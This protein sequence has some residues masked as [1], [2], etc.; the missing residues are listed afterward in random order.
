[1]SAI[2]VDRD[3]RVLTITMN[4]PP[5]NFLTT[6]MMAE[7]H[8]LLASVEHDPAIGAVV[9]TSALDGV[10]ITHFDVSEILSGSDDFSVSISPTVAGALLRTQG[11]I[12]HL[13]GVRSALAQSPAAG[14]SALLQFHQTCALVQRLDKVVIAAI[15][16]R[17]MGGGSELALC[18]DIRI[19]ADGDFALGQPEICLGI[20]PGGGGTQRLSRAV[21]HARALELM[22]EGRAVYPAEAKAIGYVHHVVAP[23]EFT[24]FVTETAHRLAR[25]PAAAVAAIKRTVNGDAALAR[26]LAT[27]R[28]EFSASVSTKQARAALRAYLDHLDELEARGEPLDAD[29]L[30]PWLEGTAYQFHL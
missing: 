9:L 13:P 19:M 28:A 7:L 18:C 22:L 26:G 12:E 20:I 29:A 4:N 11:A 21:G 10:F 30:R 3:G 5:H 27:E 1:M 2:S 23:G 15:N 25:R 16:G 8:E 14:L 17:A 6:A 24:S